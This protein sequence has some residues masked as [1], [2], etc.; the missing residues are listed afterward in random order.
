MSP[1]AIKL[2]G[3]AG[4]VVATRAQRAEIVA[5]ANPSSR[6]NPRRRSC[7]ARTN[8]NCVDAPTESTSG[9][10][11]GEPMVLVDPA[12]PLETLTTTPAGDRGVI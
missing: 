8:W 7:F 6:S 10:V 12:S 9:S 3:A 11:D 1:G 5:G 2:D 4:L